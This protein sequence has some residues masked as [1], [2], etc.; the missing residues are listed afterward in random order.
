[1]FETLNLS[2]PSPITQLHDDL[3]DRKQIE[4]FIK[5]DDLIHPYIQ[6]N[7]WRKLKYNLIEA[8]S[9]KYTTLLTFGGAYSNHIHA[10]A[11]AGD[12]LGFKT[13]GL[14]RGEQ[15]QPLNP[16]LQDAVNWGMQLEF[17]TRCEYKQKNSAEF[18]A[19]LKDTYGD[20]YCLPEGGSNKLALSGCKEII[21]EVDL[22]FDVVCCA[23]GTGGTLAGIITGLTGNSQALGFQVLKGKEYIKQEVTQLLGK[24]NFYSKTHWT[25]NSDYHFGGYARI[26][27]DLVN[28]IKN[29]YL[30][31]KIQLDPVYTGKMFY[32]LFD[33]VTKDHFD[34]NS[35]ILAIHT[36]G[37]Q[38]NRG[39]K[40]NQ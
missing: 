3:F 37:I 1:M 4:F 18:T 34:K 16:T 39:F 29:F 9:K 19:R 38:G 28:F 32:G 14:I 25:I 40:L 24:N 22:N 27:E 10:T 31:Y 5:R 13:I 36:G 20:F 21:D 33:L 26:N 6:G 23:C 35:K 12:L 15:T 2:L 8:R 30:K 17:I 7:K 11:A